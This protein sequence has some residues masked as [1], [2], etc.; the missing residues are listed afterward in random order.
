[1]TANEKYQRQ[2]D[3]KALARALYEWDDMSCGPFE[4]LPKHQRDA[5]LDQAAYVLARYEIKE[6]PVLR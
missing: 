5:F 3:R 6:K 4:K 1:M 2:Q